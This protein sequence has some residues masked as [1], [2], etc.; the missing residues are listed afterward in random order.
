MGDYS[1][2]VKHA[3]DTLNAYLRDDGKVRGDPDSK[4]EMEYDGEKLNMEAPDG[5]LPFD[6]HMKNEN[7][8]AFHAFLHFRDTPPWARSLLNAARAHQHDCEPHR[9]DL[10]ETKRGKEVCNG[11]W[12]RWSVKYKWVERAKLFDEH[13]AEQRLRQREHQLS[14]SRDRAHVMVA[15]ALGRV[16]QRLKTLK[17]EELPISSLDRWMEKLVRLDIEILGMDRKP[18]AGED[19]AVAQPDMKDW[20]NEELREFQ[21]E[22]KLLF[23]AFKGRKGAAAPDGNK[24][25]TH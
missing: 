1:D 4:P 3:A 8:H 20:T 6:R 14:E 10:V 21:A 11:F 23:N 24:Q 13:M 19:M 15:V 17:P 25:Q 12:R 9:D 16:M 18:K 7:F 22:L 2:N 5:E